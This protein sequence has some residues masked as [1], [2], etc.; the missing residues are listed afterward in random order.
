MKKLLFL[1]FFLPVVTMFGQDF[2]IDKGTG[3]LYFSDVPGT[4]PDITCCAEIAYDVS[5]REIYLWRRDSSKWVPLNFAT[6]GNGAPSGDPGD[7]NKLYVDSDTG[8]LYRWTGSEWDLIVSGSNKVYVFTSPADTTSQPNAIEGDMGMVGD[9]ILMIKDSLQWRQFNGGSGSG[10]GGSPI[11]TDDQLQDDLTRK[12]E[13]LTGQT[14]LMWSR[15]S[16][17]MIMSDSLMGTTSRRRGFAFTH[18]Y[19]DLNNFSGVFGWTTLGGNKW[20]GIGEMRN[21]VIYGLNV[22]DENITIRA[23]Q[24]LV[25]DVDQMVLGS[26]NNYDPPAGKLNLLAV[27][28]NDSIVAVSNP[29][30]HFVDSIQAIPTDATEGHMY[31]V[32]PKGIWY[33]IGTGADTVAG[34]ASDDVVSRQLDTDLYAIMDYSKGAELSWWANLADAGADNSDLQSALTFS[35]LTGGT[36]IFIN[37]TLTLDN[38]SIVTV[39]SYF[40]LK[41]RPGHRVDISAAGSAFDVIRANGGLWAEHLN[42][43]GADQE[44]SLFVENTGTEIDSVTI[45]DSYFYGLDQV[46]VFD[47]LK[48]AQMANIVADSTSFAIDLNNVDHWWLSN[49]RT[50]KESSYSGAHAYRIMNYKDG[51]A[52][53]VELIGGNGAGL[54]LSTADTSFALVENLRVSNLPATQYP[55]HVVGAATSVVID[56][57]KFE[58]CFQYFYMN[59]GGS[60]K[61]TNGEAFHDQ[62][63]SDGTATQY[64]VILRGAS[65]PDFFELS[66]SKFRGPHLL[67]TAGGQVNKTKVVNNE[68]IDFV[69]Q[70]DSDMSANIRWLSMTTGSGRIDIVGNDFF[71]ATS[72]TLENLYD[73]LIRINSGFTGTMNFSDNTNEFGTTIDSRATTYTLLAENNT[74]VNSSYTTSLIRDVTTDYGNVTLFNNVIERPDGSIVPSRDHARTFSGTQSITSYEDIIVT[75]TSDFTMEPEL[76]DQ[77][78]KVIEFINVDGHTVTLRPGSGVTINGQ[79]SLVS[80]SKL[81]RIQMDDA[82]NW[83]A[84][85]TPDAVVAAEAA[86]VGY[87]T[88]QALR[89]DSTN[90]TLGDTLYIH[91]YH[92]EGDGGASSWTYV[93]SVPAGA[94]AGQSYSPTLNGNYLFLIPT[95]DMHAAMFGAKGDGKNF[96]NGDIHSDILSYVAI[97]EF[98]PDSIGGIPR[99]RWGGARDFYWMSSDI[100]QHS[101]KSN[102]EYDLQGAVIIKQGAWEHQALFHLNDA[103]GPG[104]LADTLIIRNGTFWTTKDTLA[105]RVEPNLANKLSSNT[106]FVDMD[107]G[108]VIADAYPTVIL[109]D[110]NIGLYSKGIDDG[111]G[112]SYMYNCYWFN[113]EDPISR[114]GD[115]YINYAYDCYFYNDLEYNNT[116]W[117]NTYNSGSGVSRYVNCTIFNGVNNGGLIH[118]DGGTNSPNKGSS[119]LYDGCTF[120][121]AHAMWVTNNATWTVQNCVYKNTNEVQVSRPYWTMTGDSVELDIINTTIE[122]HENPD[123]VRP[124]FL[125]G[126]TGAGLENARINADRLTVHTPSIGGRIDDISIKVTNSDFLGGISSGHAYWIDNQATK[127]HE[128]NEMIFSGIRFHIPDSNNLYPNDTELFNIRHV[129]NHMSLYD[130]EIYNNNV[131][132][133]LSLAFVRDTASAEIDKIR[134]IGAD[135][136][137]TLRTTPIFASAIDVRNT[138]QIDS[139][140][141][142]TRMGT[143]YLADEEDGEDTGTTDLN[144]DFQITYDLGEAPD[145]LDFDFYDQRGDGHGFRIQG[146]PTAT[147]ATVRMYAADVAQVSAAYNV[148]WRVKLR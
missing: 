109:R 142:R 42:V 126:V 11:G 111:N 55:V 106:R 145:A 30:V 65:T 97:D 2:T 24:T 134:S 88:M 23:D 31:L 50:T 3:V 53:G 93:A 112:A 92:F 105:N 16:M 84:V 100:V 72:Y 52:V 81:I 68:F 41:G 38:S 78:W 143:W 62:N 7:G 130:I 101:V 137:G 43:I 104:L 37:G 48:Y 75:A 51:H 34:Y 122:A 17:R 8:E 124:Y 135:E 139:F 113:V 29:T 69:P 36:D 82:D 138:W 60:L 89:N 22:I 116:K 33:N 95:R 102:V 74:I 148:K 67:A 146:T 57:F 121:G 79:D 114:S 107:V 28:E 128:R 10:G 120:I 59:D 27:N 99:I 77:L 83:L 71:F 35:G 123:S 108:D 26:V 118:R 87:P 119:V 9:S 90:L 76:Q 115:G 44:A 6:N 94:S 147:S 18:S 54:Y 63:W 58:N 66:N 132:S 144:G 140:G 110:L 39:A 136:P 96:D 14:L 5:T 46:A 12:Y 20:T 56:G 91:G 133:S 131:D 47:D 21:G 32:M 86:E 125:W 70:E 13:M 103:Q 19:Q 49:A 73:A 15:D 117:H 80:T 1:L 64:A 25:L 127:G 4:T 61:V 85:E 141:R 98:Y 40:S 45:V 129:G